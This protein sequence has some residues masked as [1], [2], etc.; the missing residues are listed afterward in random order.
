M[1]IA[2][3]DFDQTLSE[4]YSRY[5]LG[6][7]MEKAGMIKPGLQAE[8]EALETSY[9]DG[10][11]SY[12]QKYQDDKKIFSKYY[13]GINR[14]EMERFLRD[15]FNLEERI[16]PW[17][18]GLISSLQDKQYITIVISGCWDFIIEEAQEILQFDTFFASSFE[19]KEGLVTA[20][21]NRIIDYKMKDYYSSQLLDDAEKSIGLGDSEADLVFL[22]K[23]KN[24]F[25]FEPAPDALRLSSNDNLKV[26]NRENVIKEIGKIV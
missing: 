26:V 18:K 20:N 11:I 1:N 9:H 4:G 19:I 16:F 17:A 23:V 3:F 15:Q 8:V 6:Y 7:A 24:G 25:L 21:Y 10:Q 14:V 5:E 2:I 12:N 13:E 22:R